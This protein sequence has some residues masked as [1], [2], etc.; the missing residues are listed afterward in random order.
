MADEKAPV[1]KLLAQIQL[2]NVAQDIYVPTV[3][4]GNVVAGS[5]SI[6]IC[7]TDNVFPRTLTMRYGTGVLTAA[8]SL[9]ELCPMPVSTTWIIHEA[10]WSLAFKSGGPR[11]QAFASATGKITLSIFGQE[12]I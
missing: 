5:T 3:G 8:N 7:N 6:W 4:A 11:L 1:R 10:E 2:T 12:I 9:F